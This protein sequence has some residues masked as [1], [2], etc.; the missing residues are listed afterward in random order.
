MKWLVR[1]FTTS[2]WR[3]HKRKLFFE[4]IFQELRNDYKIGSFTAIKGDPLS[5]SNSCHDMA[6]AYDF[7]P[8]DRTYTVNAGKYFSRFH[9]QTYESLFVKIERKSSILQMILLRNGIYNITVDV[10]ESGMQFN[11][12]YKVKYSSKKCTVV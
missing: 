12:S 7:Y 2:T 5:Y 4:S 8:F 3:G 11:F 6:A 1:I 10:D 9:N